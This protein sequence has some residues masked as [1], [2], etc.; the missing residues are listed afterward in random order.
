M[1]PAIWG[2]AQEDD[3]GEDA[4]DHD[5]HCGEKEPTQPRLGGKGHRASAERGGSEGHQDHHSHRAVDDEGSEA[6]GALSRGVPDEIKNTRGITADSA[7]EKR[8]IELADPRD[9]VGPVEG[10]RHALGPE[11][12]LPAPSV[13]RVGDAGDEHRGER[14]R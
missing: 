6:S 13:E 3:A 9:D 14:E 2:D 12:L 7:K 5:G 10:K 8:I 4:S 11:Q 1:W